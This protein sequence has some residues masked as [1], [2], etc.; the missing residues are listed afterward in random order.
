ML[1]HTSAGAQLV[2]QFLK[3]YKSVCM[4]IR[5]H[6]E[7]YNLPVFCLI[8]I[9][10]G[11]KKSSI[12]PSSIRTPFF[13]HGGT[14]SALHSRFCCVLHKAKSLNHQQSADED[15]IFS[16]ASFSETVLWENTSL[17]WR[18]ANRW[19]FQ[20]AVRVVYMDPSFNVCQDTA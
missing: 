10:I 4:L 8:W 5:T 13:N 11:K 20:D 2:H 19:I 16:Q 18:G 9:I 12:L 14:T 15:T 1:L 6:K 17:Q 3:A 7:I